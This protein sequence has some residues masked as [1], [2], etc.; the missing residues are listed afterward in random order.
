MSM[1]IGLAGVNAA[2]NDL[3]TTANN[4]AN[5]STYG[6]KYSRAE[7]GDLVN[8]GCGAGA[9]I[10]VYTQDVNQLF[11]QGGITTTDN[12]LDFAITGCGFFQ[13]KDLTDS[14]TYYTRNGSFHVDKDGFIVNNLGQ[15]LMGGDDGTTP[16]QFPAD[17]LPVANITL[18]KDGTITAKGK[19]G[20]DV[21]I[22]AKL[23]L[24]NF[25]S[26]S[27]LQ[28]AGDTNWIATPAA[29]TVVIGAPGTGNLG[30]VMNGALESSNVN[31]TGQLVNM[32]IAQRNFGANAKTITAN[33]EM[34][35]TIIA[36]R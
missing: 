33:S 16:L 9:G 29:G 3:N 11:G 32:I 27:G 20:A 8:G 24:A 5:V 26:V 7:F 15:Q 30:N 14:G 25:P 31:L 23:T 36:I 13:V 1:S 10:G 17:Q 4:I 19:D 12:A 2:T 28:P 22:E 35:Q 34:A 6:F 21:S 18:G